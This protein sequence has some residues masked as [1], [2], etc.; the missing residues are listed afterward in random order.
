MRAAYLDWDLTN[1][2]ERVPCP[3][4][5]PHDSQREHRYMYKGTTASTS[6]LVRSERRGVE[7]CGQS[8]A[9]R[10][11]RHFPLS[12]GRK[13]RGRCTFTT[14]FAMM[15]YLCRARYPLIYCF[16]VNMDGISML[17]I[18]DTLLPPSMP[19]YFPIYL[20]S[21]TY[22]VSSS[23]EMPFAANVQ[24]EEPTRQDITWQ[25]LNLSPQ[26]GPAHT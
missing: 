15:M 11:A 26:R 2:C 1:Q 14:Y 10:E 22:S 12:Q 25:Y 16:A 3:T 24:I 23:T 21:S 19:T 20:G 5:G 4:S 17:R 18:A 6:G 9:S 7:V 13:A 8:T